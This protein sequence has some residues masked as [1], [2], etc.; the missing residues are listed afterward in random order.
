MSD[1][2]LTIKLIKKVNKL[3]LK[4]F[5]PTGTDTLMMKKNE[6]IVTQVDIDAN[7]LITN[8]LLK[9]FP[10]DDIISEE[11][12]KI[13]K[14]GKKTWY[15]DPL[16]GTTNFAYGYLDFSTCLART[17][18]NNEVDL[19][20]IGLPA[21]KEV[22]S[23]QKGGLAYLNNKKITVSSGSEHRNKKLFLFC[24]G[25]SNFGQK[26][27][28][29]IMQKIDPQKV[30]FRSFASAGIETSSVACGRADGCVL[31]EAKPWDILPGVLLIRSAGGVVTNLGGDEWTINDVGLVGSNGVC[32]EE[33]LKL[34]K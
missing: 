16:D 29:N 9:N 13:N 6:E 5:R 22:F 18:A 17:N 12:G 30:R 32:H 34:V 31:T 1:L 20:I 25:H 19:G 24:G 21:Y 10:N 2:Q 14:P 11:A 15:V 33:L 4:K 3:L 8:F 26:I 23:A 7:K 28:I 27:F